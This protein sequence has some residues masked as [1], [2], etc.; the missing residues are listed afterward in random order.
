MQRMYLNNIINYETLKVNLKRC[1][2][3]KVRKILSDILLGDIRFRK[4]Y[5]ERWISQDDLVSSRKIKIVSSEK[6]CAKS[7]G[8][9]QQKINLVKNKST[10]HISASKLTN[11]Q[12]I[13][14]HT[15][16]HDGSANCNVAQQY[17]KH[18]I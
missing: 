4:S 15:Y 1:P 17:N 5:L 7:R 14:S 3:E 9:S 6:N 10:S 12:M 2:Y 16:L 18:K 8:R 13:T 11:V